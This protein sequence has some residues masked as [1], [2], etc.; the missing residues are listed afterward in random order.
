MKLYLKTNSVSTTQTIGLLHSSVLLL[1]TIFITLSGTAQKHTPKYVSMTGNTKAYYEYLPEGYDPA[2]TTTYP[3]ILF[4][5]GIGEF[6]DGSSSQ[7]P[8]VLKQGIPK[9]IADGAFPKLFTAGGLTHRF[10]VIT[11]Q[12]VSSPKPTVADMNTV[13]N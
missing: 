7:L 3:L 8:R 5:A 4:M 2:G 11:P 13:L 9:L 12:W 1:F 10:I 6:G